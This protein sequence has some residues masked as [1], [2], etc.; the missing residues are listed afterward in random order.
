MSD[1]PNK[2]SWL[3]YREPPAPIREMYAE[4]DRS[5]AIVGAAFLET[6]LEEIIKTQ[7][8]PISNTMDERLF[9]GYGPLSGFSAKIDVATAMGL[10]D[11]H[12]RADLHKIRLLRND[13]A[14]IESPFSFDSQESKKRLSEIRIIRNMQIDRIS[15]S[16]QKN[17]YTGAVKIILLIIDLQRTGN[18]SWPRDRQASDTGEGNE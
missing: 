13:A 2:K 3:R 5:A 14:H 4:N 10:L 8:P 6:R 17:I 16:E 9:S 1:D 15:E 18:L 12:M 11:E 7:W